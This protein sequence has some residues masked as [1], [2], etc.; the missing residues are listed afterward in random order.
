MQHCWWYLNNHLGGGSQ[1]LLDIDVA[2]SR[3]TTIRK[4][5]DP[6]VSIPQFLARKA[7]RAYCAL[8]VVSGIP[9]AKP[10]RYVCVCVYTGSHEPD[11]HFFNS[12]ER[13]CYTSSRLNSKLL[14][15]PQLS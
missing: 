15:K 11:K 3:N 2:D 14:V 4:A 10:I 5:E 1:G 8:I 12:S 13:I 7:S 6:G 9:I